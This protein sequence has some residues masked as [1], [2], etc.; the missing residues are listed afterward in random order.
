M[1]VWLASCQSES[2][3]GRPQETH[4]CYGRPHAWALKTRSETVMHRLTA[5]KTHT[6]C[7]SWRVDCRDVQK[8]QPPWR[9]VYCWFCAE[10]SRS[11][12]HHGAGGG[13]LARGRQR[14]CLSNNSCTLDNCVQVSGISVEETANLKRGPPGHY[15]LVL[16]SLLLCAFVLQANSFRHIQLYRDLQ[17]NWQANGRDGMHCEK[18]HS[19]CRVFSPLFTTWESQPSNGII[20]RQDSVIMS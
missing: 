1:R 6:H 14:P 13:L 9:G 11:G 3:L 15:K 20:F 17:A 8:L 5:M 2:L 4:S 10:D 7:I 18:K 16:G 12:R 19:S